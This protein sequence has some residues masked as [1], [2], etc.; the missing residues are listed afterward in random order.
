MTTEGAEYTEKARSFR[1]THNIC[2]GSLF[3]FSI[4]SMYSVVNPP[5]LSPWHTSAVHIGTWATAR[6]SR[7]S[8]LK[9]PSPL[10]HTFV[11]GSGETGEVET[12]QRELWLFADG[13]CREQLADQRAELE[14]MAREA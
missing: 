10:S 9:S 6:T 1:R 12:L 14:A 5:G 13:Y 11:V 2:Y 4:L 8:T 3:L 7:T